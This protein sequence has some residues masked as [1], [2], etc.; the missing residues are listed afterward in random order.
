MVFSCR[1]GLHC[2]N[3]QIGLFK[4][5]VWPRPPTIM[6]T[7]NGRSNEAGIV[8]LDSSLS[9]S[10]FW[11]SKWVG[12]YRL[13]LI[14]WWGGTLGLQLCSAPLPRAAMIHTG[15]Q[16][17]LKADSTCTFLDRQY[18]GRSRLMKMAVL[19]SKDACKRFHVLDLFWIFSFPFFIT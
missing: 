11:A 12:S 15:S 6:V 3:D 1:L 14:T 2:C 10:P 19:D 4:I 9:L 18:P 17:G 13:Y 5:S 7:H 16:D 8:Q